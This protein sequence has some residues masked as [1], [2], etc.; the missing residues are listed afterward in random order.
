MYMHIKVPNK[1]LIVENCVRLH[2]IR[3]HVKSRRIIAWTLRFPNVP[4][5]SERVR[6]RYIP[7]RKNLESINTQSPD[8]KNQMV[9]LGFSIFTVRGIIFRVFMA[10][11]MCQMQ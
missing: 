3:T 6:I 10:S 7:A 5:G 9:T 1:F 11:R 2:L 8:P 4:K